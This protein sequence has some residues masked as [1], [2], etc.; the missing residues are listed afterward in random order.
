M[1]KFYVFLCTFLVLSMASYAQLAKDAKCKWLGNITTNNAVRSDFG[2]LWNQL[3]PENETKW[4][5]IEGTRDQ[6]NWTGADNCYNYCKEKGIP[7][8]FHC[9]VWGS[10]YPDWITNLSQQEQLEE[11]TEWMDAV[12]KKY[13]DLEYIDVV[14]EAVSGHAPAPFKN[15]LGGDGASGY[16]WIVKAFKMARERWP[17]A[18]LIYNDYNFISWQRSQIIDLVKKCLN[19]GAPIDAVGCQCHSLHECQ[20]QIKSG[21]NEIKQKI[22]LPIFISE[23]DVELADDNAQANFY[24]EFFPFFWEDDM[25]AGV[26]LWGYI[27]GATWRSNTG[28][29]KNGQER[30]SL[31]WLREYM[32]TDAAKNAPNPLC[33]GK[34]GNIKIDI[35]STTIELGESTTIS[36]TLEEGS[37]LV[38]SVNGE[39]IASGNSSGEATFTPTEPGTFTVTVTGKNKDGEDTSVEA[40]IK[41]INVGPYGGK[42]AIIPGTIEAE[43]YDEG[44]ADKTFSDNTPGN[45]CDDFTNY[46]RE[47]DIDLKKA[48][49]ATV[50]G[51]AQNGE[52]MKYTVEVL[53]DGDYTLTIRAGEGGSN[54]KFTIDMD[55]NSMDYQVTVPKT[56]DWGT[57]DEV[58][59]DE[60]FSLKAGKHVLT[61]TIDQDWVDIDWIK[62][63]KKGGLSSISEAYSE[64]FTITPNPA[65][66]E[67]RINGDVKKVEIFDLVGNLIEASIESK[68]DISGYSNGLYIARITLENGVL[69]KQFVVKK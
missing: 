46:Y 51:N 69:S 22:G 45:S 58:E 14:N 36:A 50:I 66:K 67:I 6:M 47:D 63:S 11:I 43:N 35:A 4:A 55:D 10:Q 40:T 53:E 3:T 1:K 62:F 39:K 2:S 30:A 31:K 20:D 34:K 17:N 56:G 49:D 44:Y 7:F 29:I 37:N 42:A 9:L 68:I 59:I 23:L 32:A 64:S 25:C 15:A 19:A 12:K 21:Y 33:G 60:E 26:T 27:D 24:K 18:I 52:W 41:V 28:L 38:I 54:G 65:S 48:G 8:K 57:F 16:D 13:P 61:I 5:S